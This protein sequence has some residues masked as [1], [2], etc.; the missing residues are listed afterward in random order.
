MNE[1]ESSV[2]A[3]L[4]FLLAVPVCLVMVTVLIYNISYAATGQY[5][6]TFSREY[7]GWETGDG[8]VI[9]WIPTYVMSLF[10]GLFPFVILLRAYLLRSSTSNLHP[11][12]DPEIL[13]IADE[14]AE[15][16]RIDPPTLYAFPDQRVILDVFGTN[17][18]PLLRLSSTFID[19]FREKPKELKAL[20]LHEY[21]HILNRDLG[22]LTLRSSFIHALRLYLFVGFC[23]Q[24]FTM[25][26]YAG[27][28]AEIPPSEMGTRM[29]FLTFRNQF[30]LFIAFV[31]LYLLVNSIYREREFLADMKTR[32]MM[33]D[34]IYVVSAFGELRKVIP[35]GVHIE[36]LSDHPSIQK[37]INRLKAPRSSDIPAVFWTAFT[38]AFVTLLITDS[39]ASITLFF[40]QDNTYALQEF[41][42]SIGIWIHFGIDVLFP[43]SIILYLFRITNV[44]SFVRFTG[45][46]SLCCGIYLALIV[47]YHLMVSLFSSQRLPIPKVATIS[48]HIYF[49]WSHVL[50]PTLFREPGIILM[51]KMIMLDLPLR[52]GTALERWVFGFPVM[53]SICILV[54]VLV[55]VV[56]KLP[57]P[58]KFPSRQGRFLAVAGIQILLILGCIYVQIPRKD[59]VST[60]EEWFMSFYRAHHEQDP[61][62]GEHVKVGR[63]D[64]YV[65]YDIENTFYAIHIL[66]YI[67]RLGN[68]TLN[69]RNELIRWL[70]FHQGDNGEFYR[71]FYFDMGD[72]ARILDEY[73]ILLSLRDLD[74]LDTMERE[75]ATQYALSES[76]EYPLHTF[77]L[78]EIL[79]MLDALD[80]IDLISRF[81]VED[82]Q[83]ECESENG[84]CFDRC[85]DGLTFCYDGFRSCVRKGRCLSCTYWTV[86]TLEKLNAL[87][88]YDEEAITDC[89][90]EH[91]TEDGGFCEEIKVDWFSDPPQMYQQGFS[92]LKSTFYAVKSLQVLGQLID[93]E[94]IFRYVL[95]CQMRDGTVYTLEVQDQLNFDREKT[96]HYVLSCQTR[97]GGFARTPQGEPTFEDTYYA[98][99][100]LDA[101]DA[102]DRL[103]KPYSGSDVLLEIFHGLPLVLYILVGALIVGDL[104]LYYRVWK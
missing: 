78:A 5:S 55:C 74:A 57:I 87:S 26:L 35:K 91:Y 82:Y 34:S 73:Y 43:V 14:A 13:R 79:S 53:F 70:Q 68:L 94:R 12:E 48:N 54:G 76:D 83:D 45:K 23:Y 75:G 90:L 10:F 17:K 71:D 81:P 39:F 84:N 25:Y 9:V 37:R 56:Q 38:L 88:I 103:N 65:N 41:Y 15:L 59:K 80:R 3:P 95:S 104:W 97:K 11:L 18:K 100:I 64:F 8:T 60:M 67:T 7:I 69:Q 1:Q 27:E 52:F 51:Q 2:R 50:L 44:K 62:T 93:R 47:G 6:F 46:S 77:Y 24:C 58:K 102:L 72:K 96:I 36:V 22:L 86:L 28:H 30:V 99:E 4:L 42:E 19:L 49:E 63:F 29:L 31:F 33:G 101:L 98:V 66:K 16:A 40:Y 89:I 32:F 20:L 61:H 92:D 21:S 85:I